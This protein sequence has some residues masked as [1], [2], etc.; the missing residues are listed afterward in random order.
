M[1]CQWGGK[2]GNGLLLDSNS[3]FEYRRTRVFTIVCATSEP[4]FLLTKKEAEEKKLKMSTLPLV[5]VVGSSVAAGRGAKRGRGWVE[6]VESELATQGRFR[7]CNLSVGGATTKSTLALLKKKQTFNAWSKEKEIIVVV[8]L[9]LN[10]EKK[11]VLK[12]EKDECSAAV[13]ARHY[14]L[15]LAALSQHIQTISLSHNKDSN[16]KIRFFVCGPYCTCN[17]VKDDAMIVDQ[18]IELLAV[19]Y[20][21]LFCN[22][23]T[24]ALCSDGA[25]WLPQLCMGKWH[26]NQSGHRVM[27]NIF[28]ESFRL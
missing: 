14:V 15:G 6:L 9:S 23:H 11:C 18:V 20:K 5:V 13:V 27:A 25:G 12:R 8:S 17:N 3:S 24:S 7:V 22:F 4:T 1:H 10:N 28:L 21:P 19:T 2:S 26:P 16:Q